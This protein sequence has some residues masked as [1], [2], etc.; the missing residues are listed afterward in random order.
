MSVSDLNCL[1]IYF[2]ISMLCATFEQKI[3]KYSFSKEKH[4]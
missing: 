2:H 4:F 1:P 3:M